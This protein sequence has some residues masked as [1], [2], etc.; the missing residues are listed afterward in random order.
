M[1]VPAYSNEQLILNQVSGFNAVNAMAFFGAVRELSEGVHVD[2]R[3]RGCLSKR[4]EDSLPR[5]GG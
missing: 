4:N 5:K 3:A 2:E 1:A